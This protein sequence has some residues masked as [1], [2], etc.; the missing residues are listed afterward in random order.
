MINV[1]FKD[2]EDYSLDSFL[3]WSFWN[4]NEISGTV[5]FV[6]RFWSFETVG[7]CS[8][9]F[10]LFEIET[11]NFQIVFFKDLEDYS[12]DF[13]NSCSFWNFNEIPGP[14]FFVFRFWS[15]QSTER[16]HWSSCLLEIET[17]DNLVREQWF[18]GWFALDWTT[19]SWF[20][21]NTDRMVVRASESRKRI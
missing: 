4:F 20:H 10:C 6:F 21:Q 12:L 5:F 17:R 1:F 16:V 3:V 2:L 13:K 7:S 8:W 19:L 11:K 9:K 15:F 14:V 18:Q